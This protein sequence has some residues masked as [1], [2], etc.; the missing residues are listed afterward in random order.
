[1]DGPVDKTCATRLSKS[2]VNGLNLLEVEQI[3]FN[4]IESKIKC[5]EVDTRRML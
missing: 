3:Q 5:T 1:M 4:I 2:L